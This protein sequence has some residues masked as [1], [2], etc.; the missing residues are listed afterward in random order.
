MP[1]WAILAKL[2]ARNG[3]ARR[4]S[5]NVDVLTTAMPGPRIVLRS[6]ESTSSVLRTTIGCIQGSSN[7]WPLD[8]GM[9]AGCV[10]L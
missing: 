4:Y 1:S 7:R 6:A 5:L 9:K 8:L 3:E 10:D 2:P